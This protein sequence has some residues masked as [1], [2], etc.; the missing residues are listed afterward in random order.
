MYAKILGV[1]VVAIRDETDMRVALGDLK[2][3]RIVLVDTIGMGQRD[4][5]LVDQVA[6]L[7]G[8]NKPVK[9]LL[10]LSAVAQTNVLAEVVEAYKGPSLTG[11]ILT[12][13]DESL[14]LGGALDVLIRH[15]LP[16]YYVTNGQR[17]PEDLHLA[18]PL[19]LIE[20][21]IRLAPETGSFAFAEEDVPYLFAESATQ[22]SQ[23]LVAGAMSG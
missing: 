5:R 19:Y 14:T 15:K 23:S 22:T 21:A 13:L 17:V 11:C 9:R 18:S 20:R 1:P 16:L 8:N 7:C 12:K 2:S 4:R 6:L 3:R 10:L